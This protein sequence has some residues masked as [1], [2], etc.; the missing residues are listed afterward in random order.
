MITLKP[1]IKNKRIKVCLFQHSNNKTYVEYFNPRDAME[2]IAR[3][4]F[5]N[6]VCSAKDKPSIIME[7]G[8]VWVH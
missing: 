2:A 6:Q 3:V 5:W 4:A 1:A 7:D 8:A